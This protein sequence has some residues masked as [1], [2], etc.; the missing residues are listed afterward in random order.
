MS[1]WNYALYM[2]ENNPSA[3][4]EISRGEI[5]PYPFADA[6]DPVL[7]RET[8]KYKIIDQDPPVMLKAMAMLVPEWKIVDNSAGELP[9]SPVQVRFKEKITISLIPYAS[10]K[11]R[12]SEIPFIK[13]E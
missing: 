13:S 11:L 8:G 3:S 7:D 12:L 9:L 1:N 6:G 10:A 4:F 5:G 2:D